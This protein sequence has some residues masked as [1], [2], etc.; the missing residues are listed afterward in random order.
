[1]STEQMEQ[2]PNYFDTQGILFGLMRMDLGEF[3]FGENV[4]TQR[5]LF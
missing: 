5:I 4:D 2:R 1:M 3:Y